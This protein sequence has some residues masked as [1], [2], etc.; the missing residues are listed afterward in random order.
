MESEL[1]LDN[2]K[3]KHGS[4][5]LELAKC[6]SESV[7]LKPGSKHNEQRQNIQSKIDMLKVP[8]R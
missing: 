6:I 3:K 2:H 1:L 4:G 7:K 5:D 8:L